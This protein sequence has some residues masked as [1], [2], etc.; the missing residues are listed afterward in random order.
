[1]NLILSATSG[2]E[3][4]PLRAY[5][6][7]DS[8]DTALRAPRRATSTDA[9]THAVGKTHTSSTSTAGGDQ[10]SR[11]TLLQSPHAAS[12][13]YMIPPRTLSST[14]PT[15]GVTRTLPSTCLN[16]STNSTFSIVHI[17]EPCPAAWEFVPGIHDQQPW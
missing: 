10:L 2:G 6:R 4:N 7:P 3:G 5:T 16:A 12:V 13:S 1:M 17:N 15:A 9:A 8:S 14:F 11:G